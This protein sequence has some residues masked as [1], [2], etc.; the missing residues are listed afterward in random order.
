LVRGAEVKTKHKIVLGAV[1]GALGLYAWKSRRGNGMTIVSGFRV[2]KDAKTGV[3][4]DHRFN[5]P[6]VISEAEANALIDS[7]GL[8]IGGKGQEYNATTIMDGLAYLESKK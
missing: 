7:G 6:R 1:V 2:V 3:W 5:P 4:T 8:D